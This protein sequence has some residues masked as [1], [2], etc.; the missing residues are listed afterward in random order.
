[1]SGFAGYGKIPLGSC[2]A[3]DS[4]GDWCVTEKIHGAN[5]SV[6]VERSGALRCAKRTAFLKEHEDFFGHYRMLSRYRAKFLGLAREVFENTETSSVALFGELCGGKYPHKEVPEEPHTRPVQTGVWYNPVVEFVLFD[7]GLSRAGGRCFMAFK[8]VVELAAKHKLPSV[9]VLLVGPRGDCANFNP[10]FESQVS[11]AF[12]LPAI[13][14][15]LAEGVV[16]KPWD[17]ETAAKDRPILKVKTQEFCEGDGCPP[18]AGDPAMR[19]Y[20]LAQVNDNRLD[21][22]ASKVGSLELPDNWEAIVDLV[23]EDIVQDVGDDPTLSALQPQ[24]RCEAF[25]LITSRRLA[26]ASGPVELP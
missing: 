3:S 16:V 22:A 10:R 15:N 12:G 20:L 6:H 21:S 26:L 8:T 2:R 5:F 4:G 25:D 19:D 18:A 24:L 7:I 17:R 9:P 14:G 11:A 1:M 23:L 13:S